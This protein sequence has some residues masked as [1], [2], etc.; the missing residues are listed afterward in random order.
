MKHKAFTVSAVIQLLQFTES[1]HIL[2]IGNNLCRINGVSEENGHHAVEIISSRNFLPK[3][4]VK[5]SKQIAKDYHTFSILYIISVCYL[6]A[7][8]LLSITYPFAIPSIPYLSIF[9]FGFQIISPSLT[10]PRRGVRASLAV[11]A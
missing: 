5:E 11:V 6:F 10:I 3:G 4:Y 2:S 9:G 1:A 8:R 7:I